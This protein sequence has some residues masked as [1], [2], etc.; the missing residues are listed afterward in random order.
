MLIAKL[1]YRNISYLTGVIASLL[2]VVNAYAATSNGV[3]AYSCRDHFGFQNICYI[4]LDGTGMVQMTFGPDNAMPSWDPTG[5][6][7]AYTHREQF[8]GA[9]TIVVM[10]KDG[11]GKHAISEGLVP[12][13]SPDGNWIAF[14]SGRTGT[15]EIWIVRSNGTN[16]RQL[17][18]SPG[19]AK[20]MPTWS[21]DGQFIAYTQFDASAKHNSVW[22][23]TASGRNPRQ[24]TTGT[25][26]NVDADGDF[27]NTANDA[28]SP[29]WSPTSNKIAFWSGEEGK[30]GQIWSI[31][32]DGSNRVQLILPAKPPVQPY[33]PPLPY[34]I[35]DDP[36]W[37]PDGKAILFSTNRGN[38]P[39][40]WVMKANGDDQLRI[41]NNT[42][43]PL[44]RRC[45]AATRAVEHGKI[46]WGP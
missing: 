42:A 21:P 11:S 32:S 9:T 8:R 33:P 28:R 5:K 45:G 27:I 22:I 37:S 40:M 14:T 43:G 16:Q 6:L 34:S 17:T 25:W 24:L 4:N 10:N 13:W 30:M 1:L 41:A 29:A 26:N 31:N 39:E 18:N 23:M 15:P 46:R 38:H 35:S 36:G 44:P 7:L 12:A 3:I 2:I 19:I 20:I